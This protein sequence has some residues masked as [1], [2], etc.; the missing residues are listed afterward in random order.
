MKSDTASGLTVG[1]SGIVG[2]GHMDNSLFLINIVGG[3]HWEKKAK[4]IS[5][6]KR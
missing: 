6:L 2:S 1:S 3:R 5:D 4:T